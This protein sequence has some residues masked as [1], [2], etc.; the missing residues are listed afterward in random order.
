M[1]AMCARQRAGFQEDGIFCAVFGQ[2]LSSLSLSL[3]ISIEGIMLH[4]SLVVE[5][6]QRLTS[7]LAYRKC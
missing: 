6:T 3:F 7:Y 5:G 2:A 4:T 1:A